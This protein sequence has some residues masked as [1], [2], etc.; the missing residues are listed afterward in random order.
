MAIAGWYKIKLPWPVGP[1]V[2]SY[3][4]DDP[5]EVLHRR[6]A[7]VGPDEWVMV[8]RSEINDVCEMRVCRSTH[9]FDYDEDGP[10]TPMTAYCVK[11]AGHR[12]GHGN[13]YFTWVEG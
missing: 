5:R 2:G 1:Y 10:T 3:P 11:E 13:G 7:H 4:K 6:L 9:D 8:K 12:D